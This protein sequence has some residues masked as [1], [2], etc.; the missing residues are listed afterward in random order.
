MDRF[1][2]LCRCSPNFPNPLISLACLRTQTHFRVILVYHQWLRRR[3]P[4]R[5][6]RRRSPLKIF[7]QLLID[8]YKGQST[9][10][11]SRLQIKVNT[12]SN[13]G[14]C[15]IGASIKLILFFFAVLSV[16]PDDEDAIQCKI[17]SL[18][19]A[20]NI[21]DALSTIVALSKKFPF[22]FGFFKVNYR[23]LLAL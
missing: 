19:K 7:S 21:D 13:L 2:Q 3:S 23:H 9:S 1:I 20:D 12:L 10:R 4:N 15:W 17:V 5:R 11:L 8:I 6:P 16:A 22:N 18:I 14:I